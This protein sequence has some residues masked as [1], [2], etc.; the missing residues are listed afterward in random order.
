MDRRSDLF[1]LG[2]VLYAM[3]T[4]LAPFRGES[5]IEVLRRV[6][7]GKPEPVRTLNPEPLDWLAEIIERLHAKAA[8]D[9]W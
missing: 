4:G 5:S 6:S 9:F 3:A 7:D 1:S 8:A 2:S